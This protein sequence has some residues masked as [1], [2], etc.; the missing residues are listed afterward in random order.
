M[1]EVSKAMSSIT[2]A[3][4]SIAARLKELDDERDAL[5]SALKALDGIPNAVS[6]RARRAPARAKSTAKRTRRSG[7]DRAKQVLAI[8]ERDPGITIPQIAKKLGIAPPYLYQRVVPK[9][10]EEG[11]VRKDGKGWFLA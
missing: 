11:K 7:E 4:S 3:R 2:E 8:I 9:L 5:L 10:S 1:V 6:T